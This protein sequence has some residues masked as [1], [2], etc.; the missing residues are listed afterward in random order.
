MLVNKEADRTILHLW[1]FILR[2]WFLASFKKIWKKA[3]G[4]KT[5]LH[6]VPFGII[7]RWECL[8]IRVVSYIIFG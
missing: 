6:L 5:N 7:N 2:Q 3:L 1:Q 4:E 8:G